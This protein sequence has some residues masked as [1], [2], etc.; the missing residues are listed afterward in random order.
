M[1]YTNNARKD[2]DTLQKTVEYVIFSP[3]LTAGQKERIVKIV[4][5]YGNVRFT[6]MEIQQYLGRHKRTACRAIQMM[7]ELGIA[8][9]VEKYDRMRYY[10]INQIGRA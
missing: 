6:R 4:Y 1:Q 10:K 2:N 5:R 8:D 3:G 7:R 9:L